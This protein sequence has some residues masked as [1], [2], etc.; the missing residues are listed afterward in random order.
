LARASAVRSCYDIPEFIPSPGDRW[1]ALYREVRDVAEHEALITSGN[2]GAGTTYAPAQISCVLSLRTAVER[3]LASKGRM[4]L[5]TVDGFG[6]VGPSDGLASASDVTRT[7][8]ACSAFITAI[9]AAYVATGGD[10]L[11]GK[12]G[13]ASDKG[14]GAFRVVTRVSV[15]RVPDTMRSRR[16]SLIENPIYT[17]VT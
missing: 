14:A 16:H 13:V 11:N 7:S 15:G 12:V 4:Y 6:I 5:P 10:F 17:A 8:Q 9:N 3:G 1:I 2:A